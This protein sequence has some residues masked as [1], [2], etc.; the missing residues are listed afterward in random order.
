MSRE[1]MPVI[2]SGHGS[3]ML[4]LD[5]NERT[6][7][8]T[9]I[10]R[11][12]VEKYGKPKAILAVSAHWYTHGTYVQSDKLPK[13]IYDMYGFPHEL[14]D[15]KYPVKGCPELADGVLALLGDSAS[16][17]NQW[18]IDHGSWTV[19]CH[20]FPNADIPVAQ[21][22]VDADLTAEEIYHLGEKLAP[23]RNEGYLMF[24]SGNV[25]HNLRQVEWGNESGSNMTLPSTMMWS[26]ASK[27]VMI[28][29]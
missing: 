7:G 14:Y 6:E 12:V 2:F 27:A 4:A 5:H 16:I 10:G 21:L 17:N 23:L 19:L 9:Q 26:G 8:L 18:G 20:M 13:Q 3:P 11:E 15:F 24:A 29:R 1:K 28:R 25:V 22:S